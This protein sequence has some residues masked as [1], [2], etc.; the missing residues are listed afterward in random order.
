MSVEQMSALIAEYLSATR[1]I[2]EL[3]QSRFGVDDLLRARRTGA[4]PKE[5]VLDPD[6]GIRFSFHGVGCTI[7]SKG[8]S[9][10]FDFGPGGRVDGFDLWRLQLFLGSRLDKYPGLATEEEQ[11]AASSEL[12]SRGAIVRSGEPPS[13]HLFRL[14]EAFRR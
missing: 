4:L 12:I 6:K 13:P 3:F 7:E 1:Q 5:G 11:A 2:K 9:I 14:R 8:Q 10:D